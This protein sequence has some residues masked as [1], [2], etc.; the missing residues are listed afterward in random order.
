MIQGKSINLR[1]V[2]Q[3][4][5]D[6]LI[7][8]VSDT[9]EKGEFLNPNMINEVMYRK[10][11]QDTG[12]WNEEF[13][14]LVITDKSGRLLGDISFFKGVG[15]LPGYEIGYSL[16]KSADRGKGY[17]SEAL[18]LFSAYLFEIKE[19]VHRLEIHAD[20][21]NV[22]SRKVAE[23]CGFTYEGMKRQAVFSR[24]K[25]S[26]LAIYSM[27]RHECPSFTEMIK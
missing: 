22:A 2:K 17:T 26:D 21:E 5:I 10:R 7:P 12:F 16:H 13:G 8:L 19:N 1:M 6:E 23:K 9:K 11:Y 3:S 24:G 18:K 14:M 27:L 20:K 4:D 15:Y 25:Y